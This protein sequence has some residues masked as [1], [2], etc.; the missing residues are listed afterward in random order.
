MN[1]LAFKEILEK[2]GVLF[3]F[4]GT[5]SQSILSSVAE[6]LEKELHATGIAFTLIQNIFAVFTEQMQNIM[7]Y[8]Q[9]RIHL[10]DNAFESPGICIVGYDQAK[11]HFFVGSANI[12]YQK[13]ESKL[14]EKLDKIIPMN[15][16]ELREY[17]KVLRRS[18][19]D[20][21]GR[22]AGLGFLE[23][24]KKSVLPMEYK[25]TQLDEERSFF[26][27]KTYI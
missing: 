17:Y 19:K 6:T 25:I 18:G 8:S 22:G 7:S 9:E 2:E 15:R 1:M 20:K 3:S 24:A 13:D 5:V 12:M 16:D 27:I 11:G 14:S 21:H 4:S 10:G 23:M 26:E